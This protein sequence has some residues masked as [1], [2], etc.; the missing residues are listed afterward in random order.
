M[1]PTVSLQRSVGVAV[2]A[3]LRK[4]YPIHTFKVSSYHAAPKVSSWIPLQN[5]KVLRDPFY[6]TSAVLFKYSC[7]GCRAA[8]INTT[9]VLPVLS[10]HETSLT[11]YDDRLRR[12]RFRS[13]PFCGELLHVV[14]A[15]LLVF[16]VSTQGE[17][18][19]PRQDLMASERGR[20]GRRV[21]VDQTRY[22][23]RAQ[24]Q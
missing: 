19:P 21:H 23:C 6:P 9:L 16:R 15:V 4:T 24:Q 1:W 13:S 12:P 3:A 2:E 8:H 22:R 18:E 10:P 20:T 5:V 17:D 11:H 14:R 7:R